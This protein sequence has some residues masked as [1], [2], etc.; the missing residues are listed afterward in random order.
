MEIK[1]YDPSEQVDPAVDLG[2]LPAPL[3]E[4]EFL[5]EFSA[6][7]PAPPPQV[8]EGI[9]HRGCKMILGGTSKS[10]KSWCLLDL[11][12]S[13]A[14]GESWWGRRCA[15]MPVVYINFEL[16]R[17]S[18]GLRINALA[19]ARPECK[20]LGDT[21]ALWNLRGRSTDLSLLRP[22]LEEQLARHQF[23]LII[24]DP[25]Y[26]LLGD[27]DENANGEIASLM[28]EFEALAQSS[29]AAVVVAHHFAKGD[30]SA[31]N[32]IDRMSG[33]GAWARDPDSILVLT[34][35]EE[36]DC[37]TVS[38]VLRNL[39]QVDEFVVEWDYPLMRLAPE[40]NPGALRRPQSKNKVCSDREFV[41]AVISAEGKPFTSI[42]N[43]AKVALKM[44]PRTTATYLKRL[45]A[46]GLIRS[47]GGLY[48]A[49]EQ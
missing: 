48:W 40:L 26:K 20:G 18:I 44:S 35:H 49:P 22:K 6:S 31:K 25:A 30:S 34:P 7:V 36:P 14:S 24:L 16:H 17:W 19:G 10:N 41:E 1:T 43:E 42:V 47:G 15:K 23:G 32:A 46:R 9:L 45:V 28:N 8:I 33:A 4:I 5:R 3:P 21:L 27:R 13:V 29:G 38:T 11:A 39:P 2:V 37:F 12:I